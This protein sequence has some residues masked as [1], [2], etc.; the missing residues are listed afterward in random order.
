M[1]SIGLGTG[2]KWKL[3]GLEET[4]TEGKK[5]KKKTV[6]GNWRKEDPSYVVAE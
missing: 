5:D 4:V 2:G 1:H 6:F 3:K